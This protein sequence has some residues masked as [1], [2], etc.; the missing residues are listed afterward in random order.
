[1]NYFFKILKFGLPYKR[2]A[3]LNI[4]F[5]ILY[6]LFSALAY[7]AMIPMM[8]ILFGTTK[9]TYIQPTFQGVVKIK[10][11]LED[12]FNYK[13]TQ[14]LDQEIGTALL[15]VIGMIISLFFLKNIFNYLAMFFI[16]FLRNGVLKDIRNSLYKKTT[17]LPLDFF[18]EKK[19]GDLM[20]RISSDVLELQHSF[21][22]I[23]ELIVRDPL[24]IIF[25]L[26]VMFSFSTKLTLFVLV[27]IPLSGGIISQIGKSLKR[28]SERVQNEQGEFL[29]II[30]ETLGGIKIIKALWSIIYSNKDADIYE[31]NLMRRLAGLMYIDSVTMGDI[32]NKIKKE[33]S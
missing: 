10:S 3:F 13:V 12:F 24:T 29:S 18:S 6:A 9:K 31:T 23:L 1:M 2:Y 8:Q 26:I 15:F 11:F 22:S 32:K 5:N 7:V 25:S 16:T 4:F 17:T 14:Y 21:L 20:A 28:K 19:K 30:E 33:N 27:F